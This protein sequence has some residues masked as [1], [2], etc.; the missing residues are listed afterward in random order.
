[1]TLDALLFGERSPATIWPSTP[2]GVTDHRGEPAGASRRGRRSAARGG[3]RPGLGGRGHAAERRRPRG[4]AVRGVAGRRRVRAAQPA[5]HAARG[6]PRARLRAPAVLVT[7]SE[8]RPPRSTSRRSC[9]RSG[10]TRHRAAGPI[11]SRRDAHGLRRRRRAD[12]VHVGHHRPT[13]AG[14]APSRRRARAARRGHRH[15]AQRG[16]HRRRRPSRR[17]CRTWSRCRSRCGPGSTRCCS[18]SGWVPPVV[19][20][21]A[22][23]SGRVRGAGARVRH[24]LARCCRP[25]P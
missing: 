2:A 24:P 17:R 20:M 18:R 23:R 6:R 16:R 15:G 13:Q 10:R 22:L 3:C 5:P 12:P 11:G 25:R 8:L 19:L 4:D 21:D 1:M 9:S 7:T 14:A